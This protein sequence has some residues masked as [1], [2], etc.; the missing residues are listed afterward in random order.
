MRP[1]VLRIPTD[2]RP[3]GGEHLLFERVDC[4]D[5]EVLRNKVDI[6]GEHR[7]LRGRLRGSS[8]QD[9]AN[10][11][12]QAAT[13]AGSGT[14]PSVDRLAGDR[15]IGPRISDGMGVFMGFVAVRLGRSSPPDISHVIFCSFPCYSWRTSPRCR[16]RAMRVICDSLRRVGQ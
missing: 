4:L 11:C 13:V 14:S 9:R 5:V 16:R 8:E 3:V 15:I 2:G 10:R 7:I 6:V 1:E 12:K